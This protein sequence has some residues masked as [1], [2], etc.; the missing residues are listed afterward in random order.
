MHRRNE[1][2]VGI[3]MIGAAALIS[4]GVGCSGRQLGGQSCAQINASYQAAVSAALAC[5][6]GAPNQCEVRVASTPME[7]QQACGNGIPVNDDTTI[8]MIREQWLRSCDPNPPHSC[9]YIPCDPPVPPAAC[10]PDGYGSA[11]GTCV[12]GAGDGGAGIPS[13]AGPSCD[14]LATDYSAAVYAATACTPGAPNQCQ[15][16]AARLPANCP[17]LCNGSSRVNDTTSVEAAR[18]SW[19]AAGC[20]GPPTTCVAMDCVQ[21]PGVCVPDPQGSGSCTFVSRSEA[22]V[23]G[24]DPTPVAPDAGATCG[25]LEEEYYAAVY[26]AKACTPGAPNQCQVPVN[27]SPSE[28]APGGCEVGWYVNDATAVD[29]VL[30][31]WIAQCGVTPVKCPLPCQPPPGRVTCAATDAGPAAGICVRVD[32]SN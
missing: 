2:P 32:A 3:V 11:T 20:G 9:P 1:R 28:F 12:A 27:P 19:L 4:A 6:P 5:T 18:Q 29:A 10:I 13:D 21:L 16:L 8:E 30:A 15:A 14:Q 22:G 25:Q 26:A 23:V 7:C 31:R 17:D 24:P